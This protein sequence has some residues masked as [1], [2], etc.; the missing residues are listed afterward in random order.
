[1]RIVSLLPAATEMVCQL[2][3]ANRLVG[4]SHEC[5]YPP[6]VV[7][8]PRVTRSVVPGE[9]PSRQIDERV[10]QSASEG[11]PLF[12]IQEDLLEEL[13]PEL[14]VTQGLCDVC[15]VSTSQV[16][17]LAASLPG[18]P[19]VVHLEPT[20]LGEMLDALQILGEAAGTAGRAREVVQDLRERIEKVR[21]STGA[22]P[23]RPRVALLE[24]IDPLF[25]SGHWNPE[26]VRIAGGQEVLGRE[27]E[28]SRRLDWD[29]L[30]RADPEVLILALCG[31]K[32][33][34]SLEDWPILQDKP[35]FRDMACARA[36]KI[37]V[38][39]GNAYFNRPG[40]RLVD[41]LEILAHTL[42]PDLFTLPGGLAKA[43]KVV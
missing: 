2:G 5:D 17:A 41:S 3:L 28:H 16:A 30:R 26:M 32:V 20:R 42:H 37:F 18:K 27:G 36:G 24:W 31:Y 33:D 35:G 15:A 11:Q 23:R 12:E 25:S 8:L 34:R 7:K 29:E 1:M 13:E 19:R 40:P 4:I 10:S 14:I 43:T 38:M 21:F 9:L 6:E 22:P 39:D